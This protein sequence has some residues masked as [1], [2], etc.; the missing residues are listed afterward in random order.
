LPEIATS[1]FQALDAGRTPEKAGQVLVA[2]LRAY[3]DTTEAKHVEMEKH[4]YK[5]IRELENE[6][7]EY[8]EK[9]LDYQKKVKYLGEEIQLLE[10]QTSTLQE[11]IKSQNRIL[12][13]QHKKLISYYG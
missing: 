8:I 11:T 5:R 4:T 9:E 12:A 2:C 3:M 7:R 6:R 10:K 13:A 1:A